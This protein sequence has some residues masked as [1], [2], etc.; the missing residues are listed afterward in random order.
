M[1]QHQYWIELQTLKAHVL[2]L[3]LYQLSSEGWERRIN[4][5][6]AVMSSA[7]IGGWAIWKQWSFV[8]GLLIAVSQVASVVYKY[9]PFK[10]RI[11]PISKAALELSALADA[12][13]KVWFDVAGGHL[14]ERQIHE[15]RFAVRKAKNRIMR[16]NFGGVVL[17]EN[18]RLMNKA[19]QQM[20]T[21][22]INVF[23]ELN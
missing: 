7:S 5:F 23:P 15:K 13:E 1:Y 3:E 12:A 22:F 8:W 2:Y 14:T 18:K 17:P 11:K 21:Y 20:R 10:S 16:A 19:E 9:L 6:L 4:I